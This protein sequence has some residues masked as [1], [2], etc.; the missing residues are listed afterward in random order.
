MP[1]QSRQRRRFP[2]R[3]RRRQGDRLGG[4][5]GRWL[6]EHLVIWARIRDRELPADLGG[7]HPQ[8]KRHE[9]GER[10][11]ERRDV[12]GLGDWKAD[13]RVD[14]LRP[15]VERHE[16]RDHVPAG[17]GAHL[18]AIGP[19]DVQADL[20]VHLGLSHRA[21]AAALVRRECLADD[22]LRDL[23]VDVVDQAAEHRRPVLPLD[24]A[25]LHL[26]ADR[27]DRGRVNA[28][29]TH[30]AQEHAAVLGRCAGRV[31]ADAQRHAVDL[32]E[33]HPILQR[34]P[35]DHE[36]EGRRPGDTAP[37]RHAHF[38]A[39]HVHGELG[40]GQRRTL[41]AVV[42]NEAQIGQRLAIW[43]EEPRIP[44]DVLHRLEKAVDVIPD[45]LDTAVALG[46][47]IRERADHLPE[48]RIG[49]Q[50]VHRVGD[51]GRRALGDLH[52]RL[53]RLDR[54]PARL[55]L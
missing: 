8:T 5:R 44:P 4:W 30:G 6:R 40:R 35:L 46:H 22:D 53:D 37:E 55:Q 25:E 27:D 7:L 17:G 48:G 41:E 26:H 29:V 12:V 11:R 10:I 19:G 3:R 1:R 28:D 13:G 14:P 34:E 16:R 42:D 45:Q 18:P 33:G 51:L 15:E 2:A 47:R 31:P 24:L 49:H 32:A 50:V 23:A 43:N 54:E 38:R 20:V 21:A 39:R 9:L 52:D 36:G